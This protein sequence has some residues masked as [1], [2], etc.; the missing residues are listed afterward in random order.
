M[1][2]KRRMVVE[3]YFYHLYNRFVTGLALFESKEIV[4]E[5]FNEFY[6]KAEKFR[7]NVYAVYC[8]PNHFHSIIKLTEPN[9]SEFL[10]SYSTQFAK[11]LN[12][13]AQRQGHIF[14]S[15]HKTQIV[16]NKGY[17]K[18]LVYYVFN[19]ARRAGLVD[20][21]ED[22]KW[23]N[24]DDIIANWQKNEQYQELIEMTIGSQKNINKFL[25]WLNGPN[26]EGEKEIQK[27][28]RQFISESLESEEPQEILEKVNRRKS[29]QKTEIKRR[30]QDL[31]SITDINKEESKRVA[32]YISS[33]ECVF[34]WMNPRT[35]HSHLVWFV[36]HEKYGISLEKIRALY[37]KRRHQSIA[38]AILQIRKNDKKYKAALELIK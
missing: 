10:L 18:T 25:E 6:E 28:T 2:R 32:E 12:Q 38:Q 30:K 8:M 20:K 26:T 34:E 22:Y 37:Q 19:N 3:G 17:L 11:K 33:N 27:I 1:G 21:V 16:T 36:L 7:I 23:S 5:F 29:N 15:R 14:Q 31:F 24:L 4:D 13:Q 35:A 9:L